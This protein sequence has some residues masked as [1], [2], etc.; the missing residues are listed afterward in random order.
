MP[1]NNEFW[2]CS[3]C[4]KIFSDADGQND[5]TAIAVVINPTGTDPDHQHKLTKVEAK[6]ATETEA[7]NDE[8]YTCSECGKLFKDENGQT[9]TTLADVTKAATGKHNIEKIAAK[10]PTCTEPGHEEYYYCNDCHKFFTDEKGQNEVKYKDKE[11]PATGHDLTKVSAKDP[12][13]TQPGNKEY[14]VCK[15]CEKLFADAEGKDETTLAAVTVPA[16]DKITFTDVPDNAYYRDAVYWAVDQGVTTGISSTLFNPNG[17]CTR[18]EAVTFL[19]RAAG[20]PAP[21]STA[22]P[23]KDVPANSWYYTAV[24]WAVGEGITTGT[25][26]TT[27]SPNMTC[28]RAQIV[29]LQW[30]ASGSPSVGTVSQFADVG[31]NEWF[32]KA[33]NWAV[34]KGITNGTT[35]TTFSP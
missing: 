6:A 28:S 17:I 10:A 9:E 11:I 22:M 16:T 14:Y 13:A 30:R 32:T 33:V 15:G 20:C 25:D 2:E 3:G 34:N 4:D 27:F 23:F 26:A 29:T 18:A 31:N 21:D 5:T 7:G 19:W 24:L 1:G 8:Y 12:T 35:T